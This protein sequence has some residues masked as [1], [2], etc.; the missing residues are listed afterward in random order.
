MRD[1]LLSTGFPALAN[2]KYPE[3]A[4]TCSGCSN[5]S[6][7]HQWREPNMLILTR[8]EGEKLVLTHQGITIWVKVTDIK[9]GQIKLSIEAPKAVDFVRRE[10]QPEQPMP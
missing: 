6:G 2:M 4:G 10:L 7:P 1:I 3:S 5:T 8:R 9:G